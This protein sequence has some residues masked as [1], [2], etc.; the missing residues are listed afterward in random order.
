MV[1]MLETAPF[2]KIDI[3]MLRQRG[4]TTNKTKIAIVIGRRRRRRTCG[5][6]QNNK[7][8]TKQN[9]LVMP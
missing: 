1:F 2:L 3:L 5:I 9:K 8:K 7:M 6:E 4:E